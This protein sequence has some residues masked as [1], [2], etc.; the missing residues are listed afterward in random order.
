MNQLLYRFMWNIT[1]YSSCTSEYTY[2]GTSMSP[3]VVLRIIHL[4]LLPPSNVV[5]LGL[6]AS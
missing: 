1:I 4:L 5:E 6:R 2:L 3:T